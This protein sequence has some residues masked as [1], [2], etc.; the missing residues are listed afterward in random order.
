MS[1]C[2]LAA[3][4]NS[5]PEYSLSNHCGLHYAYDESSHQVA[6]LKHVIFNFVCEYGIRKVQTET[7]GAQQILVCAYYVNCVCE[8]L[9][10]I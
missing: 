4:I 8:I 1:G 5:G 10:T 7:D 6:C 3:E 2:L 9:R